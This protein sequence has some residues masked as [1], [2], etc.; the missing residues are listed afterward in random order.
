MPH[1]FKAILFDLDGTIIDSA[2]DLQ[3]TMNTLLKQ[4]NRSPI[5]LDGIKSCTGDGLQA[6]LDKALRL[7]GDPVDA[8]RIEQLMPRFL[9]IYEGI[10]TKPDCIYPDMLEFIRSEYTG[11]TKLAIVTNKHESATRRILGQLE[12]TR[13]FD[14][15]IGGDSLVQRKPHPLPVLHALRTLAVAQDDAVMIGDSPNDVHAAHGAG[16]PSIILRYGY[17][18]DWPEKCQPTAFAN[19]VQECCVALQLI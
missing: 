12:L 6:M 14:V 9:S 16:I 4:E 11:G 3:T 7:T 17:S 8:A 2:V 15:I 5:H 10:V 1:R 18:Q 19:H 13:Y